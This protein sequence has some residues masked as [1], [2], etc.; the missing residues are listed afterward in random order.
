MITFGDRMDRLGGAAPV[1]SA[2]GLSKSYGGNRVV[3]DLSL[4]LPPGGMLGLIGPNGAGKTTLFNL[5]AGSVRPDGGTI[6]LAGRDVTAEPPASAPDSAAASRS[7]A[8]SPA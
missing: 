4:D 5:L 8:H 6:L 3:A 1:L 2:R 7:P